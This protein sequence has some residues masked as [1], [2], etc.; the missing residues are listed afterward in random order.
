MNSALFLVTWALVDIIGLVLF[1]GA[2][3]NAVETLH[4]VEVLLAEVL[5]SLC[6]ILNATNNIVLSQEWAVCFEALHDSLIGAM[7]KLIAIPAD[8]SR[9]L[10][11]SFELFHASLLIPVLDWLALLLLD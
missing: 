4:V 8:L 11:H 7:L 5:V 9:V 2:F 1:A 10:H 3:G 6:L